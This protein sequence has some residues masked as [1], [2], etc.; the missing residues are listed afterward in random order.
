M[1]DDQ[2]PR[3]N[4]INALHRLDADFLVEKLIERLLG[5]ENIPRVDVSASPLQREG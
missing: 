3:A 2:T 1:L 5:D 4:D